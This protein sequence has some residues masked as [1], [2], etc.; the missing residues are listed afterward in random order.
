MCVFVMHTQARAHGANIYISLGSSCLKLVTSTLV[1]SCIRMRTYVL[2][3]WCWRWGGGGG[4]SSTNCNKYL[5]V[6]E[7]KKNNIKI[8]TVCSLHSTQPSVQVGQWHES[9]TPNKWHVEPTSSKLRSLMGRTSH[10]GVNDAR[11]LSVKPINRCH[12]TLT[13]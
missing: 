9:S 10:S 11:C 5:K 6:V 13:R 7:I 12:Y 2:E 4:G 8:P 3:L 1:Q